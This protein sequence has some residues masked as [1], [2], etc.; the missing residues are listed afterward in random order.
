MQDTAAG[1]APIDTAP[2]GGVDA[3]LRPGVPAWATSLVRD[4]CTVAGVDEPPLV[5]WR[6]A[7]P[8]RRQVG[9]AEVSP[10]SPW[11]TRITIWADEDDGE[12]RRRLL[13]ELAHHIAAATVEPDAGGRM[14]LGHNR[15]FY[16]VLFAV[17]HAHAGSAAARML[18]AEAADHP[19][20]LRHARRAGVPELADAEMLLAAIEAD[21]LRAARAPHEIAGGRR[22]DG[23]RCRICGGGVTPME[24]LAMA[25]GVRPVHARAQAPE[26]QGQRAPVRAR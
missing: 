22:T 12:T 1:C 8:G 3:L 10:R 20:A 15:H 13:H 18:A 6:Q 26:R 23:G 11:V 14:R 2:F 5:R 9:L 7:A 25:I 16:D 17:L 4:A 24:R 19:S 21:M